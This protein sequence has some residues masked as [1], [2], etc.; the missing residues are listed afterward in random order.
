MRS[1][2]SRRAFTLVEAVAGVVII[3]ILAT[4]GLVGY[5]KY[6]TQARMLEG[7]S[8]VKGIVEAQ[9]RFKSESGVYAH[10][11]DPNACWYPREPGRYVTAWGGPCP[12]CKRPWD[13]LGVT[14][15]GPVAF[16]FGASAGKRSAPGGGISG[17][18]DDDF[19]MGTKPTPRSLLPGGGGDVPDLPPER[20]STGPWFMVAAIADFDGDP[21]VKTMMVYD[22]DV[23][24]IATA[25]D[26]E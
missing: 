12:C 24:I 5:R 1:I 3:G 23:K 6:V 19:G 4:I 26:G 22:S 7:T 8:M 10:I 20:V 21:R 17:G 18:G 11:N 13:A 15:T 16:G 25:N 2:R 9:E 14:A